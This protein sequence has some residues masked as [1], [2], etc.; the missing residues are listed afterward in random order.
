MF[1]LPYALILALRRFK[2]LI[3]V[4]TVCPYVLLDVLRW[5]GKKQKLDLVV[6][7]VKRYI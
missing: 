2:D 7:T 4:G 6:I 3:N 1:I 5:G